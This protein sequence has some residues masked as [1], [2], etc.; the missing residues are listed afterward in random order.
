MN[1]YGR[2]LPYHVYRLFEELKLTPAKAKTRFGIDAD[3][4]SRIQAGRFPSFYRATAAFTLEAVEP[5][6]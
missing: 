2:T 4:V 6:Y 5:Q 3:D 1:S